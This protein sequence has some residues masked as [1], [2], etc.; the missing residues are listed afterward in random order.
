[1]M[2]MGKHFM[3]DELI[4]RCERFIQSTGAVVTKFCQRCGISTS[5]YYKW[6]SGETPLSAEKAAGINQFLESFGF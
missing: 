3:N 4:E 6:R 1:M 5:M 2:K